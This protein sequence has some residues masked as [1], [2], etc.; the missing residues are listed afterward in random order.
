MSLAI[1]GATAV[2]AQAAQAGVQTATT[3]AAK[4]GT[5]DA[6]KQGEAFERLLLGQLSKTLVDSAMPEDGAS[7][8]A[9]TSYRDLLPDAVTEAL[10]SA[11]GVGL[12][13]TLARGTG[14]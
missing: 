12:A 2:T 14:S 3:S 13:K 7:S 9:T 8:A 5:S 10:M 6:L 4:A 1:G 11:G